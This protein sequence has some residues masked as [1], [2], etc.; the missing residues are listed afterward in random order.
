MPR[1]GESI[2]EWEN[3]LDESVNIPSQ[4]HTDSQRQARLT[5]GEFPKSPEGWSGPYQLKYLWKHA[6]PDGKAMRFTDFE[7]AI[8]VATTIDDCKGIT[9]TSRWYE[10]RRG[11][12]LISVPQGKENH[13]LAS[14]IK[15]EPEPEYEDDVDG[16]VVVDEVII[17]G[18]TYYMIADGTLYDPE[19]SEEL[20]KLV[21]G[22]LL[23]NK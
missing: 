12:D 16:G 15:L 13:G 10:L 7:E 19:T 20:G 14:W 9:K 11:P 4:K 3:D 6:G 2:D 17:D 18:E 23:K 1:A 21:D 5:Q 8:K 22:E